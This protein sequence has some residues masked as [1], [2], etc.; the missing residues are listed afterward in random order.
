MAQDHQ[1]HDRKKRYGHAGYAI[2]VAMMMK[3]A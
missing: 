3:L 2:I 1:A